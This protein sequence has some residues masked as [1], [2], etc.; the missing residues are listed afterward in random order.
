MSILARF[1]PR[2]LGVAYGSKDNGG[3][4][5]NNACSASV[6]V[7]DLGIQPNEG[8]IVRFVPRILLTKRHQHPRGGGDGGGRG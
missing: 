2:E 6:A 5:D 3:N 1:P 4:K 8:L 7:R